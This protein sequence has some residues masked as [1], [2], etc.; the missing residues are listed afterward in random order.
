MGKYKNH[1]NMAE[2]FVLQNAKKKHEANEA[3]EINSLI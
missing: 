2:H 1:T 3:H